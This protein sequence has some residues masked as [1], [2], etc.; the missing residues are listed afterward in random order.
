[1]NSGGVEEPREIK[2]QPSCNLEATIWPHCRRQ[3]GSGCSVSRAYTDR[4][5]QARLEVGCCCVDIPAGA[6]SLFIN[7]LYVYSFCL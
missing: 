3:V 1:M 5:R 4:H 6:G 2:K 7:N